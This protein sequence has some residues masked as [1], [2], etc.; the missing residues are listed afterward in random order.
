MEALVIV[1]AI[2][3]SR[4]VMIAPNRIKANVIRFEY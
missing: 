3:K 1:Q 4:V 2:K